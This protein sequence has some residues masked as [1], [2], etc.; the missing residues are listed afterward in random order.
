MN[1]TNIPIEERILPGK[2]RWNKGLELRFR[3]SSLLQF[4]HSHSPKIGG[5]REEWELLPALDTQI[6]HTKFVSFSNIS[7]KARDM[8]DN[9]TSLLLN[10]EGEYVFSIWQYF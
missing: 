3:I 5:T 1:S 9:I 4:T 2:T 10:E 6:L 8:L 7:R